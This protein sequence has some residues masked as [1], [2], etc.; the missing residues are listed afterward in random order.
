MLDWEARA[1]SRALSA[2]VRS[3]DYIPRAADS[4]RS[5]VGTERDQDRE[6]PRGQGRA[7]G[8]QPAPVP[9][10]PPTPAQ[11]LTHGSQRA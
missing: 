4:Q 2:R 3:Q 6:D 9:P 1:S 7:G 5:H 10:N 8:S 11:F